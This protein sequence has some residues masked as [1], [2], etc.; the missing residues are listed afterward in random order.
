MVTDSDVLDALRRHQDALRRCRDCT[1]MTGPPVIGQAVLSPV[2]LLGQA[3]GT[4]EIEVGR[5]FAW[6]AG[7]NLFGWFERIGLDEQAIR[8]QVYM[9]AVCRCF[10]GKSKSGGDRVP[11]RQEIANCSRWWRTELALLRPRLVI[12]VGK[13][14]I[15]QFIEVRRLDEVV[16]RKWRVETEEGIGT[17]LIPLPHPS[18]AS[19]WHRTEPGKGL[20]QGALELI[21]EHPAWR[22]LAAGNIEGKTTRFRKS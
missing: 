11:S 21:A 16:G 12:P 15:S 14:A 20:L 7:K 22:D 4:K 19:V 18:G 17:D 3:P 9:A 10:P 1:A 8:S 13:L 2:M 5:P 6:T